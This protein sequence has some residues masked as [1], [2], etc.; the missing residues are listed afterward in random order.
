M[1][2]WSK[3]GSRETLK[4][5]EEDV[6]RPASSEVACNGLRKQFELKRSQI[7]GISP[8]VIIWRL[9]R[10]AMAAIASRPDGDIP[11]NA[12]VYVP[13]FDF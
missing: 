12:K 8:P 3:N 1:R 5:G 4:C 13:I 7:K 6:N 11:E 2:W 9:R 10:S